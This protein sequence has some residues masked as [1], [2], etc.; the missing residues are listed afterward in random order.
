MWEDCENQ[1][2]QQY[3]AESKRHQANLDALDRD[4]EA[5]LTAQEL[6]RA[7]DRKAAEPR[8]S[9][10]VQMVV[11]TSE[12]PWRWTQESLG[13]EFE[14][15]AEHAAIH[16]TGAKNS[17][18]ESSA[19]WSETSRLP[20]G[21]KFAAPAPFPPPKNAHTQ[22]QISTLSLLRWHAWTLISRHSSLGSLLRG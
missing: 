22:L 11:P 9:Q 8:A 14:E 16:D 21:W 7:E 2:K 5:A 15:Y 19:C 12:F 18:W 20:G 1:L 13:G 17:L 3:L 6:A 10:D 4:L